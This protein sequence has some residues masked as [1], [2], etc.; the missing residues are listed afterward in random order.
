MNRLAEGHAVTTRKSRSVLAEG[1][2]VTTRISRSAYQK[3]TQY[4]YQKVTQLGLREFPL[5]EVIQRVFESFREFLEEVSARSFITQPRT[6]CALR[7]RTSSRRGHLR[8]KQ[9]QKLYSE[10]VLL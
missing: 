4:P 3:L 6:S 5:Y 10:E 8:E 9:I 2:A 7:A 1:H